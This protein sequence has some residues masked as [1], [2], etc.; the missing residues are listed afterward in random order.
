MGGPRILKPLTEPHLYVQFS[1]LRHE[2]TV[3]IH[4]IYDFQLVFLFFFPPSSVDQN[5]LNAIY[6]GMGWTLCVHWKCILLYVLQRK[7]AK[8]DESKFDESESEKIINHI[9]SLWW[10]LKKPL[11]DK[12][13][14]Q[15]LN[16]LCS[17][18]LDF[19]I[20]FLP[21]C[22]HWFCFFFPPSVLENDETGVMDSLLEALQSGAAFRDRRKRAPRPRGK[23][24]QAHRINLVSLV[25]GKNPKLFWCCHTSEY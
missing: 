5:I 25:S 16:K 10:T 19:H 7:R 18:R 23:S 9:A 13:T 21:C 2:D 3:N 14:R 17:T 12:N 4:T 1:R 15:G 24:S 6:M 11:P 22:N 8:A 20:L